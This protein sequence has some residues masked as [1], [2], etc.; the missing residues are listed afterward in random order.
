MPVLLEILSGAKLG[1][2][3]SFDCDRLSLGDGSACEVRFDGRL[4]PGAK[5]KKVELWN[6]SSGWQVR[7]SGDQVSLNSQ[8][9]KGAKPLRSGDLIRLSDRGPDICFELLSQAQ[10]KTHLSTPAREP[11]TEPNF[12]P[13]P[14]A[15]PV[16]SPG[17]PMTHPLRAPSFMPPGAP[18]LPSSINAPEYPPQSTPAI[19]AASRRWFTGAALGAGGLIF[20][21]GMMTWFLRGNRQEPITPQPVTPPVVQT[22]IPPPKPADL[23]PPEVPKLGLDEVAEKSQRAVVWLGL[24]LNGNRFAISTAWA[25]NPTTVVTTALNAERWKSLRTGDEAFVYCAELGKGNE[26]VRIKKFQQHP[27]YKPQEVGSAES[28]HHNVALAELDAPLPATCILAQ[29]NELQGVTANQQV[30]VL[31]INILW[32]DSQRPEPFN[33]LTPPKLVPTMGRIRS[34]EMLPGASD[35]PLLLLDAPLS[36]GMAGAP[37]FDSS[38]HVIGMISRDDDT[39]TVVLAPRISE[40][41]D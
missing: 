31:G 16:P 4:D 5:G 19:D 3:F 28:R 15:Q 33:L 7:A 27:R 36:F 17:M 30:F 14:P 11:P 37:V 35:F 23:P 10:Y 13:T 41:I 18:P 24:N 20:L 22:P 38:G 26:F 39:P 34:L 1:Q 25:I 32:K 12:P 9:L 40:L 8:P 21:L 2:S 6:E 29:A